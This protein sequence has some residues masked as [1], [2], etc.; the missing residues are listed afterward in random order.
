MTIFPPTHIQKIKLAKRPLIILPENPG[1]DHLGSGLAIYN[2]L[3]NT[4]SLPTIFSPHFKPSE[5]FSLWEEVK[6]I[7]GEVKEDYVLSIDIDGDKIPDIQYEKKAGKISIKIITPKG[8]APQI[9]TLSNSFDLFILLNLNENEDFLKKITNSKY[10]HIINIK[11]EIENFT[12]TQVSLS[13]IIFDLSKNFDNKYFNEKIAS[14]L[15]A[16]MIEKTKG[17]RSPEINSRSLQIASELLDKGAEREKIMQNLFGKQT[18]GSIKLWG[19]ILLKLQTHFD[20]KVAFAQI[21]EQDFLET[22]ASPSDLPGVI[23]ELILSIPT[24]NFSILIY[25]QKGQ[26]FCLIKSTENSNFSALFPEYNL[27]ENNGFFTFP[28]SGSIDYLLEKI[29]L[30][31]SLD[32]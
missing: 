13:E 3:K 26:N 30:V 6:E 23:D 14:Y 10:E 11:T 12:K 5:K 17:F 32:K 29:K 20:E 21:S 8:K 22:K 28:F 31:L 1:I 15:L 9:N 7:L 24:I 19:K 27:K 18:I 16:G 2:L 25:Q 4:G